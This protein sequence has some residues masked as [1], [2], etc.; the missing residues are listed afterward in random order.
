MTSFV[1]H[2]TVYVFVKGTLFLLAALLLSSIVS[3]RFSAAGRSALW[4]LTMAILILLPV[5]SALLPSWQVTLPDAPLRGSAVAQRIEFTGAP[6]TGIST[7][8]GQELDSGRE[9]PGRRIPGGMNPAVTADAGRNAFR[10]NTDLLLAGLGALWMAGVVLLLGRLAWAVLAVRRLSRQSTPAVHSGVTTVF[11]DLKDRVSLKRPVRIAFHHRVRIPMVWG[12]RRPTILLPEE[13]GQWPAARLRVVLLHELAHVKHRDYLFHL[14]THLAC[15]LYW[16]NPL[17]WI[18]ARRMRAAQEAACDNRVLNTGTRSF[19]YAE[20]LLDLITNLRTSR[21]RS[22]VAAVAM[23]ERHNL[24]DR[25][26]SILDD[27]LNRQSLTVQTAVWV[28][29]L[30]ALTLLPM[31]SLH[32]GFGASQEYVWLEAEG[33]PLPAAMVTRTDTAASG[34]QY[35]EVSED[36]KSTEKPPA[37]GQV[38]YSFQVNR[39]ATYAFWARARTDDGSDSFWLRVDNGEWT[40]WND[41]PHSRG[42][43][44]VE[45]YDSDHGEQ[46]VLLPLTP[47]RHT[48]AVAYREPESTLDKILIT[49][50]LEYRPAGKNPVRPNRHPRLVWLEAENGWLEQPLRIRGDATASH[51]QFIEVA[52]DRESR[53]APPASGHASYPFRVQR[54]GTYRLWGR[55]FADSNDDDSFWVRMDGG[56]WLRWNGFLPRDRWSWAEVFDEVSGKSPV[57]FGLNK[58][59][60]HLEIAYREDGARLDRLLIADDPSYLPRGYGRPAGKTKPVRVAIRPGQGDVTAP[61][62]LRPDPGTPGVQYAAVAT[63]AGRETGAVIMTVRVPRDGDYILM[64]KVHARSG[65]HNSFYVSVDRGEE[66]IWH[67]PVQKEKDR[68][69]WFPVGTEE[70]HLLDPVIYS[71]TK[72]THT[73][74][75]R[76]RED[77]TR[78]EQLILCNWADYR[79]ND[80]EISH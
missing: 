40:K 48:L 12:L 33:S 76:N 73:I 11:S 1:S 5:L 21:G 79:R 42:W 28:V 67:L 71:L 62:E 54:A 13:A 68:W 20:H 4:E 66:T 2:L 29:V 52:N 75:I 8:V 69:I 46:N 22:A 15:A 50:N 60:H 26:R 10:L 43:Q 56:K 18:G 72:D 74:R 37:A 59:E 47:G 61:M 64:G 51:W 3:R 30:G 78:L 7:E 23:G 39:K 17:V 6:V 77:G 16:M 63:G 32:F 34:T 57:E 70:D 58:G 49:N 45:V 14:L 35:I 24:K 31:A 25:I 27:G 19:D 44:W 65:N 53:G 38:R 36:Y 41:I 9:P 55:V 80:E